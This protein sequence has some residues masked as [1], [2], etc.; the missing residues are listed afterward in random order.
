MNEDSRSNKV[1]EEDMPTRREIVREKAEEFQKMLDVW[2]SQNNFLSENERLEV[3]INIRR[4]R[5]YHERR[6]VVREKI[7]RADWKKIGSLEW[8]ERQ[9]AVVDLFGQHEKL[10]AEDV[11]G[12]L[13]GIGDCVS[14]FTLID[15]INRIFRDEHLPYY[16]K[17]LKHPGF[18]A[19]K[20][21]YKMVVVKTEC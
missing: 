3:V 20:R 9:R 14:V 21:P 5:A 18:F 13:P 6:E 2:S 10:T 12:K 7:S 1:K 15:A 4:R 16:L 11:V 19:P 17:R 8:T